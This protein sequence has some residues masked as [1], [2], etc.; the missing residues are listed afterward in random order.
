M[1]QQGPAAGVSAEGLEQALALGL[2]VAHGYQEVILLS[3]RQGTAQLSWTLNAQESHAVARKWQCSACSSVPLSTPESSRHK[4]VICSFRLLTVLLPRE[5]RNAFQTPLPGS[6]F[7]WVKLVSAADA[8]I[9]AD[10]SAA[11]QSQLDFWLLQLCT[12]DTLP[13]F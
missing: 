2:R 7:S 4:P 6:W 5:Q 3:L 12:S 10:E 9:D 13:G 11:P 1:K 8:D